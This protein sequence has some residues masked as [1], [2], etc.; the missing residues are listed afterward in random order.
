MKEHKVIL[1]QG[2]GWPDSAEAAT[3]LLNDTWWRADAS[4]N[5]SGTPVAVTIYAQAD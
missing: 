4:L 5:R 1:A 2:Q 3:E